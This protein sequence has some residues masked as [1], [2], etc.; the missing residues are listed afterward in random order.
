MNNELLLLIRKYTDKL[1]EKTKSGPQE[2]L[3]FIMH[4][5]ME[6]FSFSPPVN[7]SEG[8]KWPIA[9]NSF[10][11]THFVFNITNENKILK[12][13]IPCYRRSPNYLED[14]FTD[15]LKNL[16]KLKFQKDF[17]LLVREVSKRGG[18]I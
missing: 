7:L 13:S 9:L 5:Q 8:E 1:L 14:W 12:S 3:D 15:R 6:T 17:D 2:T 4:K 10:E 16:L 11:T 18:K